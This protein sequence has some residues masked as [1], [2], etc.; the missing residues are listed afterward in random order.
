M[1]RIAFALLIIVTASFA[2]AQ[3][4]PT[5]EDLAGLT[6]AQV[7]A[8]GRQKWMDYYT[9]KVGDSTAAMCQAESVFGQCMLIRNNQYIAKKDAIYRNRIN[10]LRKH[11]T[12]FATSILEV[13]MIIS[14]GGTMW[15]PVSAGIPASVE[16]VIFAIVQPSKEK[17]KPL[18]V[19]D[20]HSKY[21]NLEVSYAKAK[22]DIVS[23]QSEAYT[24]EGGL[25]HLKAGRAAL[26]EVIKCAAS[27]RRADSDRILAF[28][29]KW[30]DIPMNMMQ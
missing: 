7:L 17:T 14:G 24:Y 11:M 18:V 6:Q 21:A 16:E 9:S 12:S 28:C 13:G 26:A 2:S 4:P 22:A 8:K 30:S 3:T 10:K 27:E 1:M 29:I 20:A 19:S 25:T 5:K 15:H 23:M